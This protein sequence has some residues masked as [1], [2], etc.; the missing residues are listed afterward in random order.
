MLN[1][2]KNIFNPPLSDQEY[3]YLDYQEEDSQKSV[4]F[5]LSNNVESI[6]QKGD[7]FY[8]QGQLDE[9]L[10]YYRQAIELNN[11]SA[12]AHQKLAMAL[13]KQGNLPEAM[14]HY[15]KAIVLNNDHSDEGENEKI[16]SAN[17]QLPDFEANLQ[18]Y[19]QI[20]KA[21]TS[22]DSPNEHISNSSLTETIQ[23]NSTN[24]ENKNKPIFLSAKKVTPQSK[25]EAAEIYVQQAL[26]YGDEQKWQ[27][28]IQACQQAVNLVPN[29]AEAYKL[30]G[31]ALQRMGQTADAMGYY[32]KALEIQPD[33]AEVYANLGSL[34]AQQK[35]WQEAQEYYQKAI[36]IKPEFA[37]AYRNLA[38]VWQQLG[39][40]KKAWDYQNKALSLEPGKITAEEHLQLGDNLLLENKPHQAIEHYRKSIQLAPNLRLGYQKLAE[41]W[42]QLGEWQE[43]ATYYRQ[44][45]KLDAPTPN[46]DDTQPRLAGKADSPALPPVLPQ[47]SKSN[48]HQ[49]QQRLLPET[50][51]TRRQENT[52]IKY[53]ARENKK[54]DLA[55]AKYQ[56]KAQELTG[57]ATIQSNLGSLYAQKKDWRKAIGHYQKAIQL[58]PNMAGAYRNL[59]RVLEKI[60]KKAEATKCWY[61]ALSIEPHSAT[62]EE[63]YQLGDTFLKESQLEEAIACYRRSIE[64]EPA[65]AQAYFRLGEILQTRGRNIEAIACFRQ[66]VR[67]DNST[68]SYHHRLGQILVQEQKLTEAISYYQKAIQIEPERWETH[69]QL[70]EVFSKLERWQEAAI[71]YNQSIKFNPE[72]SWSY[73][74]LGYVLLKLEKWSEACNALHHAIKLNPEFSW[75]YYNLGEAYQNL[76]Q[77]D[78]AIVSYQAAAKIKPDLP[79]VQQKLG[80]VLTQ[81][82]NLDLDKAFKSYLLAIRQNPADI[83]NYHQALA[84]KKNN[85]ELY[86]GLGN[87]LA[88]T[89]QL[90]EAIVAYQMALQIQPKYIEASVQLANILLKK[91]PNTNVE[92]VIGELIKRSFTSEQKQRETPKVIAQSATPP[93]IPPSAVVETITSAAEIKLPQSDRPI[94]SV[95][96]PVYNQLDYTLKC[97]KS[98]ASNIKA[99]TQVEVIVINDFSTDDTQDVLTTIEGLQLVDNDS[100]SGFIQSCNRG[101]SLAQ[102]EYL[103]FLNNDTEIRPNAIESLLDVF[104]QDEQVG[105]VGSKLVY[106]E[107]SL[108]EAGGIIWQDASGWNYGRKENPY[109][110]Q[111]N[112]LREVDYC[113][114]ASLMVKKDLFE[115][116]EGFETDFVPAYYEDTDLCFAIRHQLGLKVMY[117][118]KSEVIHYEGITSGTSTTSGVKQYQVVNAAKFKQKWQSALGEHYLR[119]Q[120][121]ANVLP[122]ARKYLGQKTILVIDSYMPCY[123]KESGARRL[124][125]LL[126]IFKELEYHVIFAAD[127]GVKDEPYTSILQD[128]QIEVLYTQNGYGLPIETQI[129]QRLPLVDLAWICRPDLNEK[130]SALVRQQPNIK[131]I[132][133]TIDLHYLRLKRAWELQPEPRSQELAQEWV[134]MQAK[135]LTLAHQA[136]LTVTVTPIEKNLLEQQAVSKVAVIPNIHLPYQ[137]EKPGFAQREGILFIGSYNH[138]PNVDAVMWLCQ[139]IMPIVWSKIPE[140][141][142]TLLGNDPKPEVQNLQS[143]RI[144]VTGYIE[145][146]SPYFL[147]SRVFVS[148]LKYGAGMKG[149]IGQSLEYGLPIVSTSIGTEGMNL[150]PDLNVLEAN[151]TEIF[152][153]QIIRLYQS[154][155]LWQQIT[156]CAPKAIASYAPEFVKASLA[157]LLTTLT[158]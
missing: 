107:G 65:Y 116:L 61:Q 150:V 134:D 84:I 104:R 74:N 79:S 49:K 82:A 12:P 13:Q 108:Q 93:S 42:E 80:Y 136:D 135:E 127:N 2:F 14:I 88:G 17:L 152:A 40:P 81:R 39:E 119:N 56:R 30:W 64:I 21:Y 102:G 105:A 86:V 32:A 123:D 133:D 145:D 62:A 41:T 87:A 155:T 45:L 106:P 76:Q 23:P 111:Y 4:S 124:F 34:Y 137:G 73:N 70:G 60:D 72:F 31:N 142:V 51:L 110:P 144:I 9:A 125:Q 19:T 68:A 43:A 6:L 89:E 130:Y 109:D 46:A 83:N 29:L 69:H 7:E 27:E 67:Y 47:V 99:S 141:Q 95:I 139:E 1:S 115:E 122:A 59:A 78:K 112:Y 131:V 101:A 33:L 156:S 153:Q 16:A 11:K 97:L 148:P 158:S 38:K 146:V 28:A 85:P 138:P 54:L 94:V 117:Q 75:S 96:I 128:N 10:T 26:A 66:A 129:R 114:G 37:G 140:V 100:N 36:V 132:Y 50:K 92:E 20:S 57:S 8:Q 90:D 113:S 98:L 77:W 118:P 5:T 15:R 53:D 18:K 154:E 48:G 157:Q 35:K 71:A 55:I 44:M 3:E 22:I 25:K 58:N 126:K 149:K 151:T 63:H 120:G 91:D 24:V 121:A 103:Y 147:N 143:D 52:A